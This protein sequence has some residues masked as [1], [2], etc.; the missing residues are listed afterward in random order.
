MNPGD[1]IN[2]LRKAVTE[3]QSEKFL[4][5]LKFIDPKALPTK[6]L[7]AF[8]DTLLFALAYPVNKE[9]KKSSEEKLA[10][11]RRVLSPGNFNL[12]NSGIENSAVISSFT[13]SFLKWFVQCFPGNA[14]FHSFDEDE[15]DVGDFL[16]LIIPSAETEILTYGWG[17]TKLFRQLFNNKINIEKIIA[18][19]ETGADEKLNELVFSQ[20]KLYVEL[21]LSGETLNRTTARSISYPSFFHKEILK[22]SDAEKIISTPLPKAT[23]ISPAEKR[24]LVENSRM[25]L[26]ALGRETDPLT[27]TAIEETEFFALERGFSIALFSLRPPHRLAFDSYVGYMMFKNGLPIAY[28]GAWIFCHRALIGINIFDAYRGGES[29]F[30]FSQLL[31]VYHQCFKVARFSVEPYQYGKDNPE[32]IASGAYWFYYRFGFRSDNEKLALLAERENENIRNI[33]GYRSA[34]AV[35]KQFTQSTISLTLSDSF[36]GP[37]SAKLSLAVTKMIAHEFDNSRAKAIAAGLKSLQQLGISVSKKP[38]ETLINWALAF[39][40]LKPSKK[41][42]PAEKKLFQ[43]M[44]AEKENGTESNYILNLQRLF[45]TQKSFYLNAPN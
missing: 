38:N 22:R 28:G 1:T 16:K 24:S 25:M 21:S 6:A 5:T 42:S 33:K 41:F 32:G 40:I 27:F 18:L 39:L 14:K 3:S 8:H 11:V 45:K 37:D 12:D 9:M 35:L 2:D 26:A 29:S 31:R 30:L 10:D 36:A 20:L 34:P 4:R 13:L 23:K 15:T 43:K 44:I 7:A 19:F 17:K